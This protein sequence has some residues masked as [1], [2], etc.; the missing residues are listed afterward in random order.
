MTFIYPAT[1]YIN[2]SEVVTVHLHANLY[3]IY[4]NRTVS[5]DFEIAIIILNHYYTSKKPSKQIIY[6]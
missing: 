3:N 6:V 4:S 1:N 5:I 2:G